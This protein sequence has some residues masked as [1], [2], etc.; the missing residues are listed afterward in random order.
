MRAIVIDRHGGP[1]VLRD[2]ELPRPEPRPG[3]IRVRIRAIGV[4]PVDYKMRQGA[5]AQPLPL[6]LGRD[7]AGDVDALGAGVTGVEIGERVFGALLGPRSNGAYAQFACAPPAFFGPKPGALSYAQAAA[8]PVAGM[9]AYVSLIHKAHLRAGDRI[10][11]AGGAG[12]VGVFALP[13][14]KRL[15]AEAVLTTAGSA[16]S[17]DFLVR[18]LRVPREHILR[19]DGLTLDEMARRVLAMN[20]GRPVPIACD[21]VGGAMK[22]LCA[23]VLD[24][25]GQLVTAVEEPPGFDLNV[26]SARG[27][28]GGSA[29]AGSGA[30]RARSASVHL[31][32]LG[33]RGRDGGPA[34]WDT[35][36]DALS[37]LSHWLDT[38]HLPPPPV[39]VV[40]TLSA[41]TVREAHARL[42]SGHT[43]GKLVL[44]VE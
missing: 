7:V 20:G 40:G 35:Y 32:N 3:E 9:T 10:F 34:E 21:F 6:V 44:T 26:W 12:G 4:N 16:A 33:A 41:D 27:G 42:E 14:A 43:H 19:Y 36:R 24:F 18:E 28:P 29:S 13:L 37:S 2:A 5:Q 31:V 11:V 25:D 30:L 15:G 8:V 23:Q 22:R 39:T 1:E 17:A 38:G